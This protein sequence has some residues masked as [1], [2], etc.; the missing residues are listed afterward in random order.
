MYSLKSAILATYERLFKPL[1][2]C[3]LCTT[4]IRSLCKRLHTL[5][6]IDGSLVAIYRMMPPEAAMHACR[7]IRSCHRCEIKML[8]FSRLSTQTSL[9]ESLCP[10]VSVYMFLSA[11]PAP[12]VAPAAGHAGMLRAPSWTGQSRRT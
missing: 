6:T 5:H 2:S 8:M 12:P 3:L 7:G 10:S 9:P 4:V 1:C 11:S